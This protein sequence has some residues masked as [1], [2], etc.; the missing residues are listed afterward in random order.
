[1]LCES[2]G[3]SLVQRPDDH[4]DKVKVRLAVYEEVTQPILGY[5]RK[6]GLYHRVNGVGTEEE[7]YEQ[8]AA[9]LKPLA[10]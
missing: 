7:I 3:G 5:Y 10:K 6:H 8:M 2:C 9:L 4:P 1:M